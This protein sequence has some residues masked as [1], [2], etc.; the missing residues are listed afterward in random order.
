[1]PILSRFSALCITLGLSIALMA[2]PASAA[3]FASHGQADQI[4]DVCQLNLA[5]DNV[6]MFWRGTDGSVFGNFSRLGESLLARNERLICATGPS[7]RFV[8]KPATS[9]QDA[10]HL[11]KITAI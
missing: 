1:M 11:S 6:R 10:T 9:P 2:L 8:S 5:H 4:I 7:V 3:L